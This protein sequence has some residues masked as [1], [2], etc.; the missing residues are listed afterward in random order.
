MARHTSVGRLEYIFY[1]AM[2]FLLV[3]FDT[4]SEWT[5]TTSL[6]RFLWMICHSKINFI[7]WRAYLAL[8]DCYD[9][10][11]CQYKCVAKS[12]GSK[13]YASAAECTEETASNAGITYESYEYGDCL[14]AIVFRWR[15]N[16]W[17]YRPYCYSSTRGYPSLGETERKKYDQL[18][19]F[20][21]DR[22][23][24]TVTN[25]LRSTFHLNAWRPHQE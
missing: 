1:S 5:I 6:L 7:W 9:L 11:S 17:S 22:Q 12:C 3:S 4:C 24:F 10:T 20:I 16:T 13:F 25:A 14:F 23:D 2:S 8:N 18:K 15:I 21:P 19:T